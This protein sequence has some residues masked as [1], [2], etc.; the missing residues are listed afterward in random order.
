MDF[1]DRLDT[2]VRILAT[3]GIRRKEAVDLMIEAYGDLDE[4][5]ARAWLKKARDRI[6]AGVDIDPEQ[7]RAIYVA[8]LDALASKVMPHVVKDQVEIKIKGVEEVSEGGATSEDLR[9]QKV[10]RK[11][12]PG[13]FDGNAGNLLFKILREKATVMGARPKDGPRTVNLNQTNNNLNVMPGDRTAELSNDELVRKVFGDGV[14]ILPERPAGA[15][16]GVSEGTE[17]AEGDDD[18]D[19]DLPLA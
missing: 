17:A 15:L 8:N 7:A 6:T 3:P 9:K 1:L 14:K 10:E 13:A 18:A 5:K 12:K 2:A 11:I 16:E 19:D 4:R